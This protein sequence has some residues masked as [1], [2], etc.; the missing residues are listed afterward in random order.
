[1]VK[2]KIKFLQFIYF[3]LKRVSR[4]H[5]HKIAANIILYHIKNYEIPISKILNSPVLPKITGPKNA[6]SCSIN[7]IKD[8]LAYL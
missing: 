5:S 7:W 1:M 3:R 2:V 6:E 8:H 4:Q